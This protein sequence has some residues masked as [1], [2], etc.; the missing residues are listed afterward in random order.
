MGRQLSKSGNGSELTGLRL[1]SR[2]Q[3]R[4][5]QILAASHLRICRPHQ[6]LRQWLISPLALTVE[7]RGLSQSTKEMQTSARIVVNL[8]G[9]S[10]RSDEVVVNLSF[11]VQCTDIS[12]C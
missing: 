2:G 11:H 1:P 5:T 3:R 10:F 12:Q 9:G 6:L 4:G 8:A 7:L